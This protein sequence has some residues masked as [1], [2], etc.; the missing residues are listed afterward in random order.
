MSFP[1]APAA[2]IAALQG[3]LA[4]PRRCVVVT[5]YNPDGDALGSSTGLVALLKAAGH[6]A[7]VVLP[8]TPPGNLHWMP[9][10]AEA[11]AWDTAKAESETAV[12]EADVVFCLDFNKQD[13]VGQLE[14]VLRNAPVKVLIDHHRDPD[15]FAAVAFSDTKACATAQMVFDIAGA[16]GWL[17]HLTADSATCLL[18]GLIT[19]SGSFRFSST[20]PHTLKVGAALMEKGAVPDRIHSAVMDDNSETR[21][22]LMGFTLS[23]RLEVL[24][25]QGTAIMHLTDKDLQRFDF[26][27]GDTEGFVN[28]GLSIRGI[29]LA[30]FF[31]QRG[32]LVK[33]SLRSKGALPVNAFLAEHFAGG[34]HANAAGGH[35]VA[36]M[37]EAIALFKRELPKLLNAH[38]A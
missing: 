3:L 28:L 31:I 34:G 33:V 27:P 4:T 32:E 30:A 35:L 14:Q 37:S 5:H 21:M 38:P 23:E 18:T 15:G 6:S 12:R 2:S 13:R 20:T 26:K 22:R 19:D 7:Q 1:S 8:N 25:E 11:I 10:Y 36:P 16:M 24:H 17:Q 9:G 29:R